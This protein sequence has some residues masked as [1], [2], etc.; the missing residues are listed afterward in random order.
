MTR[1]KSERPASR[2]FATPKT[3][4][5]GRHMWYRARAHSLTTPPHS[6]SASAFAAV[7]AASAVTSV[8]RPS[9]RTRALEKARESE[10]AREG[11]GKRT[12]ERRRWHTTR[13]RP[14]RTSARVCTGGMNA[15]GLWL[16]PFRVVLCDVLRSKTFRRP[17]P[18]NRCAKSS[19]VRT[20]KRTREPHLTHTAT[21]SRTR[22]SQKAGSLSFSSLVGSR[23][24]PLG[25]CACSCACARVCA[26]KALMVSIPRFPVH[27]R[28]S[29]PGS[30]RPKGMAFVE[31]DGTG[32][33]E[34]IC[35]Q[36]PFDSDK[37]RP[38]QSPSLMAIPQYDAA[39]ER[40]RHRPPKTRALVPPH[41]PALALIRSRSCARACPP[42]V[43]L[44]ACSKE[45][46]RLKENHVR[47]C[48][49]RLRHSGDERARV[50]SPLSRVS[51]RALCLCRCCAGVV[52]VQK[53]PMIPGLLVRFTGM[54]S[55]STPP[56]LPL[57]ALPL[58]LTPSLT[59]LHMRAGMRL[60]WCCCAARRV[61]V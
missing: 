16:C 40:S 1:A 51:V 7:S 13:D 21:R 28:G 50:T 44:C 22:R 23:A 53:L 49:L 30:G 12:R 25:L 59:C 42:L 27:E 58:S 57:I 20:R 3:S 35:A 60:L 9:G 6:A 54:G 17:R 34:K 45:Y 52:C 38:D 39:R 4:L 19:N 11:H 36:F 43:L 41:S 32:A 2:L 61:A 56:R 24:L 5:S 18:S 29:L 14:A 8:T 10:R 33:V 48:S 31:F 26:S 46:E 47:R 37:A 55:V 15:T